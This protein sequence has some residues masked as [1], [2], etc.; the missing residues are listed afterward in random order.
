MESTSTLL[1]LGALTVGLTEVLKNLIPDKHKARLTPLLAVVLGG[2]ANVYLNAWS[3][4]PEIVLYGLALGLS[5]TGLYR[6]GE[7]LL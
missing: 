2:V 6:A 1:E 5:A 4:E 7:K 3:T